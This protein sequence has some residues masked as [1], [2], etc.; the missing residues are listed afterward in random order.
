MQ[1]SSKVL[2]WTFYCVNIGFY[3]NWWFY[4]S[5]RKPFITGSQYYMIYVKLRR[6]NFSNCSEK[7]VRCD[8]LLWDMCQERHFQRTKDP[9]LWSNLN[10][11]IPFK[12]T[13]FTFMHLLFSFYIFFTFCNSIRVLSFLT[14][15][16]KTVRNVLTLG[17]LLLF[18][19]TTSLTGHPLHWFS[20]YQS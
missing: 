5:L 4:S 6:G 3:G 2:L 11:F 10:M 20:L 1:L 17:I 7:C 19:N 13:A 14:H 12:C 9:I 8:T 15:F 18:Y 16:T